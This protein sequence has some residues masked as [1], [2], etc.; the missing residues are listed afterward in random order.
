MNKSAEQTVV[1]QTNEEKIMETCQEK[2]TNDFQLVDPE[3]V[4]NAD[5]NIESNSLK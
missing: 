5:N 1:V 4:R 3:F 2:I